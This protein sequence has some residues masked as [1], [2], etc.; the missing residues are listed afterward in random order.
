V[1]IHQTFPDIR[2][3]TLTYGQWDWYDGCRGTAF[4]GQ[5][6]TQEEEDRIG[7][8]PT[9]SRGFRGVSTFRCRP[10][11]VLLLEERVC[12]KGD[13]GLRR[14]KTAARHHPRR[15]PVGERF[16]PIAMPNRFQAITFVDVKFL[17]FKAPTGKAVRRIE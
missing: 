14:K 12:V 7:V 10:L 4:R 11:G 17:T 15:V 8:C 6:I 1:R 5:E 2:T 16:T 13:S 3:G 9:V